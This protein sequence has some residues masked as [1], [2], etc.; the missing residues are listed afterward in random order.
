MMVLAAALAIWGRESS[1]KAV[2]PRD[3]RIAVR[4]LMISMAV[5]RPCLNT[6][7]SVVDSFCRL[8]LMAACVCQSKPP[9]PNRR[10]TACWCGATGAARSMAC[11][12]AGPGGRADARQAGSGD[13]E[14]ARSKEL[15]TGRFG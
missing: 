5:L 6:N 8:D 3:A 7:C 10:T 12:R 14:A 9:R 2:K 15:H 1:P 4:R 11:G 13:A